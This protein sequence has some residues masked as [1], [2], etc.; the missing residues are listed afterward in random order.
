MDTPRIDFMALT[1]AYNREPYL[2][3]MPV[4]V[5]KGDL[6]VGDTSVGLGPTWGEP[7][8]SE[9]AGVSQNSYWHP[10]PFPYT[11]WGYSIIP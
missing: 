1:A 10:T 4:T 3:L 7:E 6:A 11:L 8:W 5:T 9:K 2:A